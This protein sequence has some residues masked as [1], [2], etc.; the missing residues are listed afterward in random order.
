MKQKGLMLSLTALLLLSGCGKKSY[1][2]SDYRKTMNYGSDFL[3]RQLSDIHVG[4]ESDLQDVITLLD[5]EIRETS[6][7]YHKKPDLIVIT[8][9]SFSCATKTLVNETIAAIDSCNIPFAYT[10]GNHDTQ[11][12][13][14]K[15]YINSVL[16]KSKNSV[17]VDYDDDDIYGLTNYFIDLVKDE[18]TKYRLYIVDSNS[19]YQMG[20]TMKYDIIHQDQLDHMKR[21]ADEF[22]KIPALAFYHIPVYEFLDAY[23]LYEK[24][25]IEGTGENREGVSYGYKRTDAFDQMKDCGVM[26]MFVGHDHVNDT[27]LIYQNVLLSFGMKAT[28]EIY[29][30]Y[31]GYTDIYLHGQETL[32]LSDVTKVRI[33]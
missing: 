23:E 5:R 20:L 11:G 26:S 8:G 28:K 19:Y 10:Y 13:Y 31:I 32:S 21:A 16:R 29:H 7:A 27:S 14:D 6:S 17:F 4:T 22:G 25:E 33:N 24:G 9:D 15:Y 2:T 1:K 3:I 30:D 12:S 18:T